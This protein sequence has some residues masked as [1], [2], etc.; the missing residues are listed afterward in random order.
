VVAA[1]D[2]D[3]TLAQLRASGESASVIGTIGRG[4]RGVV[5]EE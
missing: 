4:T 2:V 5:I 1:T 3:A